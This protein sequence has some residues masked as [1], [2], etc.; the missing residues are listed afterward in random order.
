MSLALNNRLDIVILSTE[1]KPTV[2]L[3]NGSN[4]YEVD[5]AKQYVWYNGR[6]YNLDVYDVEEITE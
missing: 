5:T 2:N 1:K 3:K 6:W 4:L